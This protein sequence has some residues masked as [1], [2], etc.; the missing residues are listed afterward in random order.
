MLDTYENYIG[1]IIEKER[2]RRGLSVNDVCNGI[3][4]AAAC[5]KLESGEYAGGI[6]I[7]RALCQRLG[8]NSD[9]CGTY[10]PQAEYDEMMDRLYILEYIK[11][12]KID[13]AEARLACYEK[14]YKKNPLNSQFVLFMRGRLAELKLNN[15]KAFEYYENA[16]QQTMPWY[17][18]RQNISCLTIYEAYMILGVARIKAK[19]HYETAAY[20]L[21]RLLLNYCTNSNI[22]KWILVCIY[23]KAICEMIDIIGIDKMGIMEVKDMLV[24]CENALNVLIDTSRLHYIRPILRNIISFKSRLGNNDDNINDYEELLEAIEKLFDKFG[25][26]RELFEWYPYYVDCE[27]C[28]VNELIAERR[29]MTGISIEEL[30]GD[31]Q[32]SRNVQRIIKGY[33]SP[34][35]NTSKKLLDR[36]GLKGVLRSDVIVGSGVEAYETLDK[37]LD[38]IAM[39]K[40]ED[41]ERLISQLRTMFYSNVEINNIVLEYLEIW[42]QMLKDEVEFSEVVNRLES[43][44]PFKYSEIGKYKYLVKHERMILSTY[45]ECLGK[46]EKYEAIPDYDKMTSWITNELSKKQFASIFEDLN[47][48]YANL[49]GNAGHY[50]KSD[51]IAEEGIRIEIECERM[52]CLNTLLYC[53]AWNAGERGNVS[54]NDK[55]LCRCAYEIAKLK[56]QNIRMGLYRR[57]LEKQ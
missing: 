31:T 44:L 27:F 32:S 39:S 20:N 18:D 42:L 33:V 49:Y 15:T 46:M 14:T 28:C 11:D 24:H 25:H 13:R 16:V 19:L 17:A 54:E 45:I 47:M 40:F 51:R 38:C 30:A 29:C 8:I 21:Y 48:R 57:W 53:R 3:C 26:E 5:S 56:K 1:K 34:S 9:R 50:E 22:E 23:P 36:L 37:A 52:H 4:S 2:T 7:L 55:E 6:H 35:Y 12:G 43:L 41:A 10:L